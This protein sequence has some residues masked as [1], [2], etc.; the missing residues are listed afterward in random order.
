MNFDAQ[1]EG[2]KLGLCDLL[3]GDR[4]ELNE[5]DDTWLTY[6]MDGLVG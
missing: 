1:H 4:E 5:G 6:I 3:S 2:N